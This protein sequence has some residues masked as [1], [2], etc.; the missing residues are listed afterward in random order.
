MTYLIKTNHHT[1]TPIRYTEIN[2]GD[3]IARPTRDTYTVG[4]AHH[5]TGRKWF[6]EQ[7]ETLATPNHRKLFRLNND[8]PP[9][10]PEAD[11]LIIAYRIT[12]G[13]DSSFHTSAKGWKLRLT[14]MGYT[15]VDGE[16]IWGEDYFLPEEIHDWTPAEIKPRA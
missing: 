15:P 10:N 6:T 13:T 14:D 11:T 8:T 7:G 16:P 1:A 2:E 5:K 9:P 12:A 4:I 3:T